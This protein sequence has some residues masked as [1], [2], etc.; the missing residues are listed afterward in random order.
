MDPAK[1]IKDGG[2]TVVAKNKMMVA[3]FGSGSSK[4][5]SRNVDPSKKMLIS[6]KLE[7]RCSKNCRRLQLPP[8]PIPASRPL[9]HDVA[10]VPAQVEARRSPEQHGGRWRARRSPEQRG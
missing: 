1:K 10:T 7:T 2:A 4:K 8:R 9:V 3:K 5:H 6:A